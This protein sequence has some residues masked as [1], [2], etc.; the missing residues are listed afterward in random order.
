MRTRRAPSNAEVLHS[1]TVTSPTAEY[2]SLNRLLGDKRCVSSVSYFDQLFHIPLAR[3]DAAVTP[4]RGAA[5]SPLQ[6]SLGQTS[7]A[8]PAAGVR[9]AAP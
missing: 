3:E 1:S 6:A 2:V 5:S 4:P 9:K 7:T 8:R